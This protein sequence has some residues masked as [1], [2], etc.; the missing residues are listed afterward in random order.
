MNTDAKMGT[1]YETLAWVNAQ[2][3]RANIEHFDFPSSG[4]LFIISYFKRAAP[5]L[6]HK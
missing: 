2:A 4:W 6:V 3:G 5:T 1:M